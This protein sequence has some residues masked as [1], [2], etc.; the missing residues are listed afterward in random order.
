MMGCDGIW[1][2]KETTEIVSEIQLKLEKYDEKKTLTEGEKLAR[3][4]EE[5]MDD[6]I[7]KNSRGLGGS[8]DNMS[9]ILIKFQN[10]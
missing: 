5:F 6:N 10:H 1:Q 4:L 3:C 9:G 7:A 8:S 2:V